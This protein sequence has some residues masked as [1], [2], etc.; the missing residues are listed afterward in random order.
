MFPSKYLTDAVSSFYPYLKKAESTF[1]A[2][3]CLNSNNNCSSITISRNTVAGV[4]NKSVR[5]IARYRSSLEKRNLLSVKHVVR[6]DSG[7][8]V[9]TY[10]LKI[11]YKLRKIIRLHKNG[12]HVNSQNG[13]QSIKYTDI[14]NNNNKE[15]EKTVQKSVFVLKENHIEQNL[16]NAK[17]QFSLIYKKFRRMR[18]SIRKEFERTG[19]KSIRFD[20]Y[21]TNFP[22][23]RLNRKEFFEEQCVF[24]SDC[25][26][27][28]NQYE[29]A[30]KKLKEAKAAAKK[31]EP[32][33]LNPAYIHNYGGNRK[34]S[35]IDFIYLVNRVETFTTNETDRN[36]LINEI[37]F[38]SRFG[39]LKSSN[40]TNSINPIRKALNIGLKLVRNGSWST[41]RDL[42]Q[43][44]QGS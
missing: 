15:Q 31:L 18:H 33:Y 37:I 8:F 17:K 3:L 7:W 26:I 6:T 12:I 10:K 19:G 9:N 11:N 4:I 41:P 13:T 29:I 34:I 24:Y 5:S 40:M 16:N 39:A 35:D 2:F 32:L 1:L 42:F 43:R 22:A 36:R 28:K 20:E 30:K 14:Y 38:S 44:I 23:I 27:L 21:Q 25:L